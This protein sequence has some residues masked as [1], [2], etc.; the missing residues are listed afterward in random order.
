M[1]KTI[2]FGNE[3]SVLASDTKITVVL[4]EEEW[5]EAVQATDI[6]ERKEVA[7]WKDVFR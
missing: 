7:H 5:D 2:T 6:E 4:K 1:G 3:N